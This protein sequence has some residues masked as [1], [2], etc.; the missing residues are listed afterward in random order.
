MG[1]ERVHVLG[2]GGNEP[3]QHRQDRLGLG[4]AFD[5]PCLATHQA[6]GYVTVDT[7]NLFHPGV[8]HELVELGT[9]PVEL[10]HY[11]VD[12]V[13]RVGERLQALLRAPHQVPLEAF[14][15]R[16]DELTGQSGLS[17]DVHVPGGDQRQH[18]RPQLVE[19]G[20]AHMA[21]AST[22]VAPE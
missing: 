18:A 2:R 15:F 3:L 4:R 6:G 14:G 12:D 13:G 10:A 9:D 16:L 8:G 11:A 1:C 19:S 17:R 20:H 21:A 5:A 22:A 7:V